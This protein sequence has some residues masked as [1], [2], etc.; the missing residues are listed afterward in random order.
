MRINF[1]A[2]ISLFLIFQGNNALSNPYVKLNTQSSESIIDTEYLN[3]LPENDYILGPGDTLD[4]N[5]SRD[6]PEL[7][8]QV[9][10]DGEGTIYLPKLNRIYIKDLII[11]ELNKVLSDA[12]KK[13]VK[14]PV[15]EVRVIGY[16]PIS[17]LLEGEIENPG[18]HVLKGANELQI[19][20]QVSNYNL[21]DQLSLTGLSDGNGFSA[22]LDKPESPTNYSFPTLFDAIR[23]GGGITP[24]ANLKEVEII[25][26]DN[27]SNGGGKKSTTLN[28]EDFI[29]NGN[30]NFNI[31]IYDSDVIKIPKSESQNPKIL[32]KATLSNLNPK[33]VEVFIAGRVKNPGKTVIS[34]AGVLSDAV[35]MA[36]GTQAIKGKVLFI[37]YNNDGT[38]DK[39]KFNYR[40]GSKRGSYTNPSLKNGDLIVFGES[41]ITVTNEIITEITNPLVGIFSTYGLFQAISD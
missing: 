34:K 15:V 24:F 22:E 35:D 8:S 18:L 33:F 36:G 6:Y 11:S 40:S 39:R 21:I 14:Y 38:I 20:E 13:Y 12:Y 19:N 28:F 17:I 1:W 25:R 16:R 31:R 30:N 41:F 9:T 27:L 3:K 10:I 4:I 23:K 7:R 5:I 29:V 26:K 2:F 37:R 32:Q